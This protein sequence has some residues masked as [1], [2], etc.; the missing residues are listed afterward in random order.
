MLRGLVMIIMALDHVRDFWSASPFRP[1]DVTQTST[2]LFFTRFVTHFCAPVFVFLS[3]V[4][5]YFTEQRMKDKKSV[6]MQ[7]LK[8]GIWLVVVQVTVISFMMQFAYNLIILEVIWVIGWSMIMMAVLI[9]L[10]RKVMAGIAIV[11]IAGHNLLRGFAPVTPGNFLLA[12]LHNSPGVMVVPGFPVVIIAYTIIPWA[13]VMTAG[14]LMGVVFSF[15]PERQTAYWRTT[16]VI[17]IALFV[18]LRFLNVYGDPAPWSVQDRG[19]WYTFLSFLNVTK[20]PP[21]L[22]FLSLTLGVAMIVLTFINKLP[23]PIAAVLNTFGRVPFF[24]YLIHMPLIVLG[25]YLWGYFKFDTIVSFAF[26]SPDQWPAGYSP[27]IVRTYLVWIIYVVLLYFPC[28]WYGAY[29][30]RSNQAWLS[31]V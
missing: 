16:G 11:M 9:W 20:Y 24:Y 13:G 31:Y 7:L 23:G 10:P 1:E 3:G 12:I 17:L 18:G 28:R 26:Q 14:Y 6:A 19:G 15:P 21:S 4:S 8:R 22:L 5:I 2:E 29:K 27:S 30:G 25:A